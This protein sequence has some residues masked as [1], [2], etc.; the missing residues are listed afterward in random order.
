MRRIDGQ[1]GAVAVT[2]AILMVVLIGFTAIAVDT[3]AIWLDRK[4]LQNGADAAALALAQSCAQGACETDENTMA[5][6]Y[7]EGNKRDAN[8]TVTGITHAS[9]SVTVDVASTRSHW[10]AP[11][12][13]QD[14]SDIAAS[15]TASWGGIGGGWVSP[16]AVS[17]CHLARITQVPAVDVRFSLKGEDNDCM[18]GNPPT[19][20]PGGMNWLLTT[21]DDCTLMTDLD[22]WAPGDT[23]NDGTGNAN[24]DPL[25][26]N[27]LGEELL[28]PIFD[29]VRS[30]GANGEYHVAGY[31][32]FQ[33][34]A[35]CL[36]NSA[37]TPWYGNTNNTDRKCT[38]SDRWIIGTFV[39][40]VE[41]NAVG[42]G[43]DYGATT[44]YLTN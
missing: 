37:S 28:I 8:V 26:R 42:G 12:L 6:N 17:I 41:L 15:A 40:R 35:Y 43:P 25:L 10:F 2:V 23:G 30:N 19:A 32:V 5:D 36:N 34:H 9:T 21:N 16:F 1:R 20:L 7:A 4:E 38:G 11:V 13:G 24:C 3:G 18:I 14:S 31:A 22:G 39:K 44:A 33:V 27:L 29:D